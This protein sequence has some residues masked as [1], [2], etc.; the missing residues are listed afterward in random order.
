MLE[1]FFSLILVYA[2]L[3]FFGGGGFTGDDKDK[4]K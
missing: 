2:F 3:M 1:L 4:N